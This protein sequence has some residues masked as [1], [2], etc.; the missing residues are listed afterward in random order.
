METIRINMIF[1]DP[2]YFFYY[3]PNALDKNKL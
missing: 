2:E 3:C 1:N